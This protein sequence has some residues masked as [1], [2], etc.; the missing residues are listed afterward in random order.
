MF[1]YCI[2]SSIS[3]L[4]LLI[5]VSSFASSCHNPSLTWL[6]QMRTSRQSTVLLQ[7]DS[8]FVPVID[9]D[10]KRFASVNIGSENATMFDSI[11]N[12]Y[13]TVDRFSAEAYSS[14]PNLNSLSADL[15]L[16]NAV[17]VQ[18]SQQAIYRES[19]LR[20]LRD[21][22]RSKQLIVVLYSTASTLAHLDSL[23]S[24]VIWSASDSPSSASFTA[25]LIFGGT[26]ASSKLPATV[27][28]KFKAGDGFHTAT[29]RLSYTVPE[30]LGINSGDLER[31]IDN[32]VRSA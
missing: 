21:M 29:I 7:N 2:Y 28:P 15:K 13:T 5:T 20:F 3:I 23:K 16:Y 30:E 19:T 24:P 9:L 32:I 10:K 17:I 6:E 25:Q 26:A 8:S 1:K 27:S 11:A 31:P 12:K 18:V 14:Q 22:E 4:S